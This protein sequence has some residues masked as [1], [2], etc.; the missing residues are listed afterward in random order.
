[1]LPSDCVELKQID[2]ILLCGICYEYMETTVITPC[3]HNY[4]S[5]CIR[6]YLHYKTQCPACFEEVFEKD[7]R[8]NKALDEIKQYFVQL[9]EKLTKYVQNIPN[10]RLNLKHYIPSISQHS[11]TNLIT[12]KYQA[13]DN[14]N[15]NNYEAKHHSKRDFDEITLQNAEIALSS[16]S[17]SKTSMV[18]SF[19]TPRNKKVLQI[20][21]NENLVI[22]PVCKV[23]ISEK[24]INKH[25]DDCLKREISKDKPIKPKSKRKPLPKLV[26]SLMKES[27]IRK[28]LKEL[29]LS[30]GGD[31]KTME[32]RLQ[33]YTTIYNA[34]CDKEDPRSVAELIKQ[35]EEEENVEKKVNK[36]V[37]PKLQ[38][39]RNTAVDIIE[40]ERKKYLEINKSG[41]ENLISKIR[42]TEKVQKPSI[43]HSIFHEVEDEE[44]SENLDSQDSDS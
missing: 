16:P 40:E 4:C 39:N 8:V 12:E 41:F 36:L 3:S 37:F 43:K 25:L 17:T 23:N 32:L 22:C 30:H 35:C 13:I 38:I 2:T 7:L 28:K 27:E 20:S 9:K 1:M 21:I 42:S 31:R 11:K 34:E 14:T 33:R 18:S 5:L 24:H 44:P 29:G 15:S 26:L 19:F 10:D 6:K